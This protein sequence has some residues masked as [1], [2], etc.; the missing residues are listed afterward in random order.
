VEWW[1]V[2]EGPIAAERDPADADFLAAA[3]RIADTLPWDG[4][5]W[6]A[7][8]AALKA[9]TGR[10]GK[11][12]FLPLRRALTAHDHGPDMKALLPLIGRT[13]AISRLSA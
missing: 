11:A 10:S 12:L 13:R 9:E 4:D 3:A 1:K 7:L 8:T 2:I 5:P 6:H